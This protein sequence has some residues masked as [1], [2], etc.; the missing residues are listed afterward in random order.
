M[1]PCINTTVIPP[2]VW[3][4]SAMDSDWWVL[5]MYVAGSLAVVALLAFAVLL[6][7]NG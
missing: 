1:E 3:K 6:I 7:G 5:F 4:E 2:S